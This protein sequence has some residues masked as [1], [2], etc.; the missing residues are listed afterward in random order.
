MTDVDINKLSP[1]EMKENKQIVLGLLHTFVQVGEKTIRNVAGQ[2]HACALQVLAPSP[3]WK[4]G[5]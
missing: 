4:T 1:E 3:S 2:A 5:L